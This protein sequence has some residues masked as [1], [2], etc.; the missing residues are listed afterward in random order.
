MTFIPNPKDFYIE[1]S[2][3]KISKHSRVNKHGI[4]SDVDTSTAP[5]DVWS[6]GGIW[7]PPTTARIHD[8]VS[9]SANDTSAGTGMRTLTI[10]GLD[11]SYN[12]ASETITL[13]G[14][15]P[16]STI[17]SY[18]IID[19]AAGMTVGSGGVNA[20]TITITAQTDATVT[21]T[22]PIGF[23][24]N[25]MAIF[26]IRDNHK[27][28]VNSFY[29]TMNQTIANSTCI[30]HLMTKTLTGP[31]LVRRTLHVNNTGNSAV[32]LDVIPPL[33]LQEKQT[34]KIQVFSVSNSGTEVSGGFDL[35]LVQD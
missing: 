4:N 24:Q 9:S 26:Q 1:V 21:T 31:W 3:G 32:K 20:G 25:Q 14:T 6:N 33:E 22:I 30:V 16:V 2:K 12:F 18:V 29:A 15:T 19:Y 23:C 8:V 7:V 35:T 10:Q 11:G 28:Y 34:I 17:N 27:G 13:N 5:E